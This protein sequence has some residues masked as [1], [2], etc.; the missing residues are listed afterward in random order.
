MRRVGEER[1]ESN[2]VTRERWKEDGERRGKREDQGVSKD[3]RA[4]GTR[5]KDDK[6]IRN[7]R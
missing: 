6:E 1:K 7:V 4:E 2:R 3:G 5:R